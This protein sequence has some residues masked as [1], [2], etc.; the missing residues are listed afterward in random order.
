RLAVDRGGQVDRD[1]IAVGDRPLDALQRGEPVLQH[2]E[3]LGDL[4][5]GDQGVV[6]GDGQAGQ[7]GQVE[8]GPDVHL[9]GEGQLLAVVQVGDLDLGLA[10]GVYIAFGHRLGVQIGNRVVDRLAEHDI[11][12]DP[13]VDHRWRH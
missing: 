7:V 12:A 5:R 9:D 10:E 2:G 6:H 8:L 1:V 13:A 11:T 4:I 3:P